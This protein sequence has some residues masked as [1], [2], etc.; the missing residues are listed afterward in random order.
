MPFF[1][2]EYRL[3]E[4]S[5]PCCLI[6][7]HADIQKIKENML[8]G[9]RP[10]EC[11]K[12]WALEDNNLISD[13]QLKNS[14]FD[15]YADKDIEV[16]EE[17]CRAGQYSEQIIKLYTSNLCNSACVTCGPVLSTKWQSLENIQ[18]TK[19]SIS[20]EK[21]NC[22]QW[23]NVK[24]LSFVG[25]EPLY[26]KKNLDILEHLAQIGNT[27]CFISL[28]T[29]GSVTLTANQQE[30]FKKFKNL[31]ICLSIDG[32]GKQFEYIRY[33]TKWQTLLD[34]IQ[35]YKNI[36]AKLSVSF[37][38]S[39]LN[40]L[41]YEEIINWFNEQGLE[42]NHNLVRTPKYFNIEVLP[43]EI[44]KNLPLIENRDTFDSLLFSQFVK[45]I[46][47]QDKLKNIDIK[48]YL[49]ELWKVIDEFGE[50]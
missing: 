34:N 36:G 22:I 31:N 17:Q 39:N 30:T 5:T 47:Y 19:S 16:I 11:K 8:N 48:N 3:F 50:N 9:I 29:N 35:Q 46:K 45:N 41:Y 24:I 7:K 33:P 2:M 20:D 42:Y 37:T 26:E 28:T 15:F 6:E 21:L 49:P 40:I 25:G 12:C 14:A 43:V 32:V 27:D 23:E 44:K 1:G 4:N 38:V 10:I 18:I 13:R